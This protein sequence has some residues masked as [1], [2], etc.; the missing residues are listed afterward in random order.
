MQAILDKAT[1]EVRSTWR[2]RRVALAAAWLICVAGWISVL[3]MPNVYEASARVYL[4]TEGALRPLLKGLT[5]ESNV[6]SEMTLVRQVLLSRQKLESVARDAGIELTGS[7]PV[8]KEA[9]LVRFR[10][11]IT[12]AKDNE[13]PG[14]TTT[15]GVYRISFESADRTQA[16]NVV[17]KLLESFVEGTLGNKRTGQ[18]DAQKFL[19]AQVADYEQKLA[20][21]EDSLVKFKRDNMG[22]MPSDKSDYFERL[23]TETA[24]LNDVKSSL[25]L[26]EARQAELARQLSGEE[27]FLFGFD[28][29][30]SPLASTQG[31]S[32]VAMRIQ[33]LE[34]RR[35][36]LLLR[37]TA[38]HPEVVALDATV[39]E[40]KQRREQELQRLRAGQQ[41]TGD[42]SSSLKANPVYQSMQVQSKQAAVQVAEL[43][44][45]VAMRQAR[46]G[47][48]Q[49]M[50]N[51]VPAV[52]AEY[53][54]LVRDSG[55][56]QSQYQELVKRLETA[57]LSDD[58]EKTGTMKFRVIDPPSVP[59]KPVGPKRPLFLTAVLIA[60]LFGGIGL[61]YLLGRLRP[62]FVSP[63]QL[64]VVAGLPVIGSVTLFD[65][66]E[67]KS[68]RRHALLRL[69]FAGAVLPCAC[70]VL[71]LFADLGSRIVTRLFSMVSTL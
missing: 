42:L 1:D 28:S 14:S 31:S 33:E 65:S 52:E 39:E 46:V 24:A 69:S 34:R 20:I 22:K 11:S 8:A 51:S 60:G 35:E 44:K 59:L 55:V 29:A 15:D 67:Q 10:D 2:F 54:R 17:K 19:R 56:M 13:Q 30:T 62:V 37:F 5:V 41:A 64:E 45:D 12:M 6:D 57:K 36:E 32:D 40:L 66:D 68:A 43:R 47:Q 7:S 26:A 9:A 70:I 27:P 63:R 18:E 71:L 50:T 49:Q 4:D 21:A 38:K 58:A 25:A 53:A 16:L 61:A 48:L 23:Q 3:A